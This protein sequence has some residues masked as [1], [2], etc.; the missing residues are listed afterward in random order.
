M[1]VLAE[2][3]LGEFSTSLDGSGDKKPNTAETT[4]AEGEK[5][6]RCVYDTPVLTSRVNPDS[7]GKRLASRERFYIQ[8]V[9]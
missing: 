9:Y 7:R 1:L 2:I 8:T 3:R 4:E 5:E 6:G